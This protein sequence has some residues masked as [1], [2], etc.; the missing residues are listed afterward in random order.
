MT[1]Q[2][3]EKLIQIFR[4]R[5]KINQNAT[6]K[7]NVNMVFSKVT[8]Y[9]FTIYAHQTK[10]KYPIGERLEVVIPDSIY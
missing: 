10:D 7:K 1:E 8:N 5:I 2:G 4:N 9:Y 3:R 6:I